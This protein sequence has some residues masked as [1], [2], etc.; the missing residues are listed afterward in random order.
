MTDIK[1]WLPTEK[2]IE[3]YSLLSDM[4]RAQRKEFNLLSSK[5][6]NEHLNKIKM[7]NRV[8]EPLKK[9]LSHEDSHK[10]LDTLKEDEMPTNS[11]VV[12]IIG[13]YETAIKEFEN[14]YYI[15][16]DYKLDQFR[17]PVTRW[18]TK[19]Y[20]PEFYASEVDEDEY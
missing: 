2:D 6:P 5:K 16:D 8:L 1:E 10:F 11:G 12:L 4:L 14:R 7:A 18:M 17:D 9:L 13:Q 19:E 20:P 3:D 15:Q